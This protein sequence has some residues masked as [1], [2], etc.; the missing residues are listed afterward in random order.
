MI[1]GFPPEIIGVPFTK[2]EVCRARLFTASRECLPFP[3]RRENDNRSYH[4]PL[5]SSAA[6]KSFNAAIKQRPV[7]NRMAIE[8]CGANSLDIF[9]IIE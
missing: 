5:L 2:H 1:H 8:H 4:C 3:G 9:Q 7:L 6:L